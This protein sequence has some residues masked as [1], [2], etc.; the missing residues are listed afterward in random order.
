[1]ISHPGC[2]FGILKSL[3]LFS[4]DKDR[5]KKM[6]E[7]RNEFRKNKKAG[8]HM[9]DQQGFDKWSGEYDESIKNSKGYPFDGYYDVLGY[10]QGKVLSKG[11]TPIKVLDI[12]IGTGSLSAELYKQGADIVGVDFSEKMLEE[13]QRK[14]PK[15]RLYQQDLT[16]GLPEALE[17]EG[18][19]FIISSY[20]LHH[21]RNSQKLDVL[22]K[23]LNLLKEKGEIL[24]ADVAFESMEDLQ[25][26][27]EQAGEE[28]DDAEFY[29]IGGEM[30]KELEKR[31]ITAEYQ[32]ISYCAGV[33][34]IE[35]IN[36]K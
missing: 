26:C 2:L 10:V 32:Q 11:D 23:L 28:W 24:I 34:K 15:A 3:G 8:H 36:V 29:M 6:N 20:A 4:K 9:L 33:L 16:E 1:M 35:R 31:G 18:F 22:Q 21:L 19:D 14:I 12:G 7:S 25:A 13:A 27:K 5:E 30:V 17:E